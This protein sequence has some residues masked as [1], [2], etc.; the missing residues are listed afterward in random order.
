MINTFSSKTSILNRQNFRALSLFN[1]LDHVC[2]GLNLT[3]DIFDVFAPNFHFHAMM[4]VLIADTNRRPDAIPISLGALRHR[5]RNSPP[6]FT[7]S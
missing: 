3:H 1:P 4:G 7:F 2:F 6:W 5:M